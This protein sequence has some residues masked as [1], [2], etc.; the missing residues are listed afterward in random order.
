[1][2]KDIMPYATHPGN[3]KTSPSSAVEYIDDGTL[4]ALYGLEV[5]EYFTNIIDG[6]PTHI[7]LYPRMDGKYKDIKRELGDNGLDYFYDYPAFMHK[8]HDGKY[9]TMRTI[10]PQYEDSFRDNRGGENRDIL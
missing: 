6:I 3:G 10:Q 9:K 7:H 2:S 4:A 5:G 1:M 8:S